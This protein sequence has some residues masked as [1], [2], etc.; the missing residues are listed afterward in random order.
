MA[1]NAAAQDDGNAENQTEKNTDNDLSGDITDPVNS[2]FES[3]FGYSKIGGNDVVGFRISPVL[4]FGKFGMGLSVPVQWDLT[5]GNFR[6]DEFKGGV[7]VLRLVRFLSWGT[8]KVDPFYIRMGDINNAYL[9]LGNL[10]D[11]YSNAISF[12]KRKVGIEADIVIKQKFGFEFMYSDLDFSSFNL[13]GIRPYYRP[14]GDLDI[15]VVKTI[16]FG[17]TY[18]TDHDKTSVSTTDGSGK[19]NNLIGDGMNGFGFDLSMYLLKRKHTQIM[20]FAGYNRLMQ[21][22]GSDSL[23]SYMQMAGDAYEAE[24]D[25]ATASLI[26]NYNDGDGWNYGVLFRFGF[27]ENFLRISTRLE[28][29][30]YSDYYVPQFFNTSYEISRDM[31]IAQLLTTEA[32][33][34]T[35]GSLAFSLLDKITIGGDLMLPDNVC[36]EHPAMLQLNLNANDVIPKVICQGSYYK[37]QLANLKDAL[38][39]DNRSVAYLR[40]AY[41]FWNVMAVGFDYRWSFTR[42]E[43]DNGEF[44]YEPKNYVSPYIGVSIPLFSNDKAE[45]ERKISTDID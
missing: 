19:T 21:I 11:N 29:L 32:R 1:Q 43:T 44:T 25:L 30:S 13:L 10:I 6:T 37:G 15:P 38:T 20:V 36:E 24:G 16:E 35:Y 41:K 42:V 8:K 22:S 9:G 14:F 5:N 23:A 17:G 28:R 2:V 26:K 12:D 7:G 34:G 45:S 31:R 4:R 27:M 3:V 33:Q 18:V 40:L 39:F